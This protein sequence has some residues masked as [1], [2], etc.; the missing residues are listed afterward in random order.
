LKRPPAFS[1]ATVSFQLY[2][3]DIQL[4]A[5]STIAIVPDTT[6]PEVI[7]R[8]PDLRLTNFKPSESGDRRGNVSRGRDAAH[9]AHDLTRPGVRNVTV[10]AG[11][12]GAA[13]NRVRVGRRRRRPVARYSSTAGAVIDV[14]GTDQT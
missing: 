8:D 5:G 14:A 2:A 4:G 7:P 3:G 12:P 6:G 10:L 13:D 11:K 1:A 9:N